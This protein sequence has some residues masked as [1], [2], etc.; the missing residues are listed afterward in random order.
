MNVLR[1][2]RSSFLIIIEQLLRECVLL[3]EELTSKCT[4]IDEQIKG[5]TDSLHTLWLILH[6]TQ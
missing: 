6:T 2:F 5:R 1:A 4:L 3:D